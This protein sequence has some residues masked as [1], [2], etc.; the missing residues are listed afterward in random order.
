MMHNQR[1]WCV[2][3][4]ETSEQLAHNLTEQTWCCCN[5]FELSG[6]WFLNDATSPD[7]AQ[8]YAVVKIDGPNQKPIQVESITMSWCSYEVALGY[9]KRALAGEFDTADVAATVDSTIETPD[10]H[11][12]C[13]HCT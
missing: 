4:A 2:V 11:G 5:G 9:I 13:E 8:E 3:P 12:R 6:Y 7:G 1:R 10:E